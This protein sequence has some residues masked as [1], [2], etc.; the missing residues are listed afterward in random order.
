V[1]DQRYTCGVVKTAQARGDF[2]FLHRDRR[3]LRAHFGPDVAAHLGTLE[4]AFVAALQSS[5]TSTLE[6]ASLGRG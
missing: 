6:R 5:A 2:E 1:P 4:A 3:A